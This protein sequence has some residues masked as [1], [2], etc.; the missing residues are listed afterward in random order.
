MLEPAVNDQGVVLG[1]RPASRRKVSKM[2]TMNLLLEPGLERKLEWKKRGAVE[3]NH[4]SENV[5]RMRRN[6]AAARKRREQE[7]S[8]ATE[9]SQPAKPSRQYSHINSRVT[10][11]LNQEPVAPRPASAKY[12]RRHSKMGPPSS[13]NT[14]VVRRPRSAGGP[15]DLADGV[16]GMVVTG[17]SAAA[18]PC[19]GP[20]VDPAAEAARGTFARSPSRNG[21]K[22]STPGKQSSRSQ[23]ASRGR[24]VT[25]ARTLGSRDGDIPDYLRK[26]QEEWRKEKA[27]KKAVDP[28]CPPGHVPLSETERLQTLGV[29]RLNLD[30]LMTEMRSLPIH[31]DTI[32]FRRQKED[33]ENQICDA[34]AAI[35]LFSRPRVYVKRDA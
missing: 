13:P 5:R 23:Q 32:R 28:S 16:R 30:K 27:A 14:P 12:L 33:L 15:D 3:K 7:A 26:R 1:A 29:L 10:E 6:Q 4:L 2:T 18:P 17:R 11:Q 24:P 8:E 22:P 31:R 35:K 34:E 20:P 25:P 9:R 19:P 21:W